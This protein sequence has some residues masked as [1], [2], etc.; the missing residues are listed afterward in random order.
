MTEAARIEHFLVQTLQSMT[1]IVDAQNSYVTVKTTLDL[2]SLLSAITL[3]EESKM[4]LES[5]RNS[6][7]IAE[8]R[9]ESNV[10]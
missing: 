2:S 1:I 3:G 7:G 4:C 6:N 9:R 8:P 10:F 5:H